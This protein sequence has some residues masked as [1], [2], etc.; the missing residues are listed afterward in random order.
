MSAASQGRPN[1]LFIIT[2]HHAFFAHSRPGEFELR[3]SAFESFGA[4]GVSFDRAYSVCPLCTPARAS[5]MTGVYPSAHGLRWNTEGTWMPGNITDF[6]SGQLLYSHHLSRAG[7]RNAYVGKWHC[8]HERLPVDFGIEGWGLP[9]YGKVYMSDAYRDYAAERGLGDARALVEHNR[10]RPDWEGQTLRLHH[11]SPWRFM[12][13]SGVLEGPPEAH[14]EFFVAHLAIEKMKELT[15]GDQPWSLV[16]SFWGPHQPYYP[17]EPFASMIDPAS[18]PEYPTFHDDYEGKPVRHH[19]FRDLVHGGTGLWPEWA[20]WQEVLARCY[21]QQ[22]QLDAAIG[23][24]LA[25]LDETGAAEN[26]LV[27]WCADHGDAVA[28]HGGLWDKASTFI[29]E[30]ARVPMAIRWPAVIQGSLRTDRLVSNMDVTAT[31]LDAAGVAVPDG[32]HSRSLLPLCDD[33]TGAEWPDHVIC[34]HNGHG[35]D[36]LQRIIVRGRH[37]YVAALFDGDEL[38]DLETDPYE[39]HNLVNDPGMRDVCG[40]LRERLADHIEATGDPIAGQRLYHALRKG[41]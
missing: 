1:I 4:Q 41:W 11:P 25:A 12:N 37:K 6:R 22:L 14:E 39:M 13:G 2:D 36:V 7:Y 9:D 8:G 17:T 29:E 21:G 18:I 10:N 20:T 5:M 33:P 19:I 23:R 24:V 26:T 28:S 16:A 30:V 31:M 35:D 32:M 3:L 27:I 40:D 34:E 15:V 38:Y